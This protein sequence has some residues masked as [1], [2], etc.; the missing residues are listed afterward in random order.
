M[1]HHTGFNSNINTIFSFSWFQD[2][3]NVLSIYT[4]K[5]QSSNSYLSFTQGNLPQAPNLD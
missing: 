1:L 3:K 2:I 4:W 5:T